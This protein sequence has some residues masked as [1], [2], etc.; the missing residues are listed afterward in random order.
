MYVFVPFLFTFTAKLLLAGAAN[1]RKC[2]SAKPRLAFLHKG[3]NFGNEMTKG[4][5]KILVTRFRIPV[6]VPLINVMFSKEVGFEMK[7]TLCT[8]LHNVHLQKL[9]LIA[10]QMGVKMGVMQVEVE[11]KEL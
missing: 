11:A 3:L 1:T 7:V 4:H 9:D 2:F 10:L 8:M 6:L 5:C